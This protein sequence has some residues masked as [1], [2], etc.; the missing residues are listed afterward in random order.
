MAT[1]IDTRLVRLDDTDLTI[2]DPNE[3][4][5]GHKVVDQHGEELGKVDGLLIDSGER[6]VRFMEV[7]A[8]GF[9]GI[10]EKTFLLPVDTVTG[11]QDDTVMID[12]SREHV[13][14]APSYDPGVAQ[15]DS[16]WEETYGYYGYTPYWGAGYAF[17]GIG[18]MAGIPSARRPG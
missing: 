16:F 6:K 8:G 10:G 3:D 13:V 7:V 11:I 4:I 18:T 5:R 1:R 17:P 2:A 9:L 14:G 15:K 12:R